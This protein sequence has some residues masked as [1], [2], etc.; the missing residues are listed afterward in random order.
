MGH[1]VRMHILA[2][3]FTQDQLKL[4]TFAQL[5]YRCAQHKRVRLMKLRRLFQG[6]KYSNAYRKFMMAQVVNTS[7]LRRTLNTN[8][9]EACFA[10]LRLNKETEK[11]DLMKD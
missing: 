9:M 8:L 11:Y 1:A 2:H 4:I 7:Q 10:A 6:W 5:K 3:S